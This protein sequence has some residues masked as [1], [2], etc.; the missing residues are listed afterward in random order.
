MNQLPEKNICGLCGL[1]V[2]KHPLR[3]H[4]D[5]REHSF[6]CLGCLNIYAILLESGVIADGQDMRDTQL[7]KRS[8]ALGLIANGERQTGKSL[9][10]IPDDAPVQET[11]FKFQGCGVLPV[12]G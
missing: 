8:L 11:L 5:R 1:A 10:K 12:P 3:R 9:E 2:G 6:C 4:F 7:Y